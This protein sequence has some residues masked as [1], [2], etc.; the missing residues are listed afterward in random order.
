MLSDSQPTDH[1]SRSMGRDAHRSAESGIS[2]DRRSFTSGERDIR[3]QMAIGVMHRVGFATGI[4][5][6]AM[7]Q[8]S[9]TLY[10]VAT[11]QAALRILTIAFLAR[12]S[13]ARSA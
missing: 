4:A 11:S 1:P 7:L 13:G 10:G 6:Y 3:R 12:S 8:F 2:L 9:A 5:R